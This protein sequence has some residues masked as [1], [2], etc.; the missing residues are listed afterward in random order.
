MRRFLWI[1]AT[2]L[3]ATSAWAA[4]APPTGT[5]EGKGSWRALD[6]S[7][8]E[9][10]SRLTI[11]D[12][13]I[14]TEAEYEHGGARRERHVFTLQSAGVGFFDLVDGQGE[15]AGQLSCFEQQC[16]LSVQQAGLAVQET[17]RMSGSELRRFGEK[18][19]AGFRVVWQETLYAR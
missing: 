17:W 18:N 3:V 13:R 6:G 8:G 12:G 7:S 4:D 2:V 10:D 9:Y 15:P 14:V 16:A 5:F 1:L 11:A 19:V